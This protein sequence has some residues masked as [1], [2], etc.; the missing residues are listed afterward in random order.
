MRGSTTNLRPGL[1]T[2]WAV[3]PDGLTYFFNL[4]SGVTFHDGTPFNAEAVKWNFDRWM[5]PDNPW[6]GGTFEYWTD[7]AGFNEVIRSVDVV[8]ANTVQI[9]LSEPQGTRCC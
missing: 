4:R 1:A 9:N 7:V 5:D 3:S 2:D 8:D 6:R